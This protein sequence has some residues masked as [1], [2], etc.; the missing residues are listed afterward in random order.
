MPFFDLLL[1]KGYL[2][3]LKVETNLVKGKKRKQFKLT[4][5]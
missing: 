5:S 2:K 4:S 3:K 1:K